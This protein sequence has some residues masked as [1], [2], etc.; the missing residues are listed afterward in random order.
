MSVTATVHDDSEQ[1]WKVISTL[2]EEREKFKSDNAMPEYVSDDQVIWRSLIDEPSI[3]LLVL[4]QCQAGTEADLVS[5]MFD[6]EALKNM[7]SCWNDINEFK[8]LSVDRQRRQAGAV[9]YQT[10]LSP[11][12]INGFTLPEEVKDAV[13]QTLQEAI[14]EQVD[15]ENGNKAFI[16]ESLG[17]NVFDEVS[18]ETATTHFNS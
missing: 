13:K 12:A 3:Q 17:R 4:K 5:T 15:D 18:G 10:Y 6:V 7:I 11:G 8:S 16:R 2:Q 9:L 14:Q 1:E